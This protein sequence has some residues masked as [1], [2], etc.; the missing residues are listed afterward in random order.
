MERLEFMR[1]MNFPEGWLEPGLYPQELFE[2]QLA[3]YTPGSEAASE[4]FRNGAFHWWLKRGAS[5]DQLVKLAALTSA[6][7]DQLMGEDVQNYIRHASAYSSRVEKAF[8]PRP[9]TL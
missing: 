7:P 3:A 5:E 2:G 1:M 6:D 8:N 9:D 4:H